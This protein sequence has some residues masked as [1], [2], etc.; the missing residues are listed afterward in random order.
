MRVANKGG[1]RFVWKYRIFAA[2]L[3]GVETGRDAAG[4]AGVIAFS[5]KSSRW[6]R[7]PRRVVVFGLLSMADISAPA[8]ADLVRNRPRY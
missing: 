7:I 3:A 8:T 6:L 5:R 4:A 1:F 2:G